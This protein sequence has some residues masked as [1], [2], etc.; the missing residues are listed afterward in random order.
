MAKKMT[1]E[2]LAEMIQRNMASK[3]DVR[4]IREEMATKEVMQ[5][6]FEKVWLFAIIEAKR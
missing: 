5:E 4:A 6:G 1:I 3:E 2:D